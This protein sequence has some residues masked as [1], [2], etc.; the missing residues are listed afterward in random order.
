VEIV[1]LCPIEANTLLI[2]NE[3]FR[4]EHPMLHLSLVLLEIL[5]HLSI[6]NARYVENWVTQLLIVGK[7]MNPTHILIFK[8]TLQN[9]LP[10]RVILENHVFLEH[11]LLPQ[12]V[13]SI[14]IAV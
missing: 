8:L 14:L 11:L 2:V 5:H 6:F 3:V 13:F 10:L 4:K 1:L 9:I 12:I 7:G